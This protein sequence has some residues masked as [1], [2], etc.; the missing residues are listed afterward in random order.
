MKNLTLMV[1]AV[2]GMALTP[3]TEK[4]KQLSDA[5]I[6]RTSHDIVYNGA[7]E[8]LEYPGGDVSDRNGVC[9]DVIIRS[10]RKAFNVDLQKEIHEDMKANFD[11]YP[12]NRIW[13]LNTPDKN[14]DHRSCVT[15]KLD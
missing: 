9:T 15:Y 6:E 14:I 5:A 8:R 3:I 10:Y 12:S 13:G 7:Y 2:L 11:A 4:G 1:I